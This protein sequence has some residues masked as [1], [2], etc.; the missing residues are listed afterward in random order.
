MTLERDCPLL[1]APED[2]TLQ[3]AARNRIHAARRGPLVA[4]IVFI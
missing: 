2:P 3:L 4:K 1:F